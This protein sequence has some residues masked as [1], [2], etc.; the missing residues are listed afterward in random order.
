MVRVAG[1][2]H[3]GCRLDL[4]R[5][6]VAEVAGGVS[7]QAAGDTGEQIQVP[8]L[9]GVGGLEHVEEVVPDGE[10]LAED[11]HHRGVDV[12]DGQLSDA[13]AQG[14]K[15]KV[16]HGKRVRPLGEACRRGGRSVDELLDVRALRRSGGADTFR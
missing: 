15:G 3:G 7:E 12:A 14:L 9:T 5:L 2:H 4:C 16:T 13:Q 11:R 1:A 10:Q 8:G 6:E